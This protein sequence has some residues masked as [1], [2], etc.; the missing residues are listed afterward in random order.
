MR[1]DEFFQ[2]ARERQSIYIKKTAGFPKPWTEDTILQRYKFCSVFR[3]DDRTTIHLR[4]I[5]ET[6]RD[7]P[8]V[9]LATILYRWFNRM[10]T[11]DSIFEKE[12]IHPQDFVPPWQKTAWERLLVHMHG[13]PAIA[14]KFLKDDIIKSQP[15]GPYVTGAYCIIGAPHMPKIDGILRCFQNVLESRQP[16]LTPSGVTLDA[17]WQTIAGI[18][19]EGRGEISMESVWDWFRRYP[20][21]GDFMAYEIVTDLCYTDILKDAPDRMTWA[22]AGPGAIRGLNRIH[23]RPLEQQHPKRKTNEEMQNLLSL[24]KT[25]MHWPQMGDGPY[26]YVVTRD[27]QRA[28]DGKYPEWDMRTVEH[29]LCE[30]DKYERIRLGEGSVKGVYQ[31]QG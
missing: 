6:M 24:S 28:V 20:R 16:F 15:S 11:G 2:Y 9:L 30:F 21:S 29:T 14:I 7:K 18:C 1:V 26:Q 22:N 13:D 17:S 4:K 10:T 27:G 25:A 23:G 8:E 19:L 31:G 5:T 12:S 3:E